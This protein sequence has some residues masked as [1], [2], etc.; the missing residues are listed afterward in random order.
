[1]HF[2]LSILIIIETLDIYV[3]SYFKN[4]ILKK[5]QKR[6]KLFNLNDL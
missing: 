4:K 3:I 6:K 5:Q 2:K 1:M